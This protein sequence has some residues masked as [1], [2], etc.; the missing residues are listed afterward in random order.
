MAVAWPSCSSTYDSTRQFFPS[1]NFVYSNFVATAIAVVTPPL[2]VGTV[3]QLDRLA[4]ISEGELTIEFATIPGHTY[5]VE[6][7]ANLISW[8][9]AVPPIVAN[10]TKTQWIDSGP[11][12]TD[13]PPGPLGQRYYRVVQTN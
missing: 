4:F 5:V 8:T 6:Y 7:S 3:L 12:E 9:A 1:R 11:P 2:P 10:A 13:S